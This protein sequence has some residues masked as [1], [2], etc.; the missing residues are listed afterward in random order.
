LFAWGG[1]GGDKL[2]HKMSDDGKMVNFTFTPGLTRD[3]R[4]HVRLFAIPKDAAFKVGK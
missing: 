2:A 4:P 1:S 3:F